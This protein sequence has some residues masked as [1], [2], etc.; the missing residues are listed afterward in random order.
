LGEGEI[1]WEHTSWVWAWKRKGVSDEVIRRFYRKYG[2]P[3]LWLTERVL[4]DD[5]MCGIGPIRLGTNRA[6]ASHDFEMLLDSLG[7]PV[8]GMFRT[9]G[10]YAAGSARIVVDGVFALVAGPVGTVAGV[11]IQAARR[12]RR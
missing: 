1:S 3:P 9:A 5:A 4:G 6:C 11:L 10:R 7:Y 8:W 2:E 12:L